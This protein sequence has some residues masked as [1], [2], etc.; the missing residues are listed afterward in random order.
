MGRQ[1]N[2][3][4]SFTTMQM[5]TSLTRKNAASSISHAED[6]K[7]KELE[8]NALERQ[9]RNAEA[10]AS[11]MSDI[12]ECVDSL[13]SEMFRRFVAEEPLPCDP[14]YAEIRMFQEVM[15]KH[16]IPLVTLRRQKNGNFVH[17]CVRSSRAAGDGN[18][19]KR[20]M[21]NQMLMSRLNLFNPEAQQV[22]LRRV[23]AEETGDYEFAEFDRGE[24]FF[25]TS[26]RA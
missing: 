15:R 3:Q 9:G 7:A 12:Y 23:T 18:T 10:L 11:R 19:V 20:R 21:V 1:P 14:G 26:C 22:I 17:V 24:K 2:F 25:I 4:H 16:K 8:I 6:G 5:L 13:G